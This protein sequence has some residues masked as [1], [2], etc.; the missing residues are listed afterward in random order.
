MT[1]SEK[2]PPVE[3]GSTV[4]DVGVSSVDALTVDGLVDR[5]YA[6]VYRYAFRLSGCAAAAEDITQDVFVKNLNQQLMQCVEQI[7]VV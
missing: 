5:N 2:S 6:S 3:V 4:V 7:P 1:I